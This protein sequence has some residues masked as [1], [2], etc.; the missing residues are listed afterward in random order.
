MLGRSEKVTKMLVD[1]GANIYAKDI[2]GEGPVH[3]AAAED[4]GDLIVLLA[5]RGLFLL[6]IP[7]CS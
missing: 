3:F 5:K 7:F 1:H 4:A 2:E 6:C